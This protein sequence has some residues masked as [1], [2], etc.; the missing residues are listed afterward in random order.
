MNF[1]QIGTALFGAAFG[2]KAFDDKLP[3][4][5]R[6]AFGI[7]SYH[8]ITNAMTP[9]PVPVL[10]DAGAKVEADPKKLKF[11]EVRVRNI[12]ER[13]SRVHQQMIQG[14]RDPQVYALAREVLT[15]KKGDEWAVD[16]KDHLGEVKALYWEVRKRV[17][18]TWDPTD[19]DAFQTPRKTLALKAGDCDDFVSLLGA[20]LRS[21]GHKVRSRIVQTQGETTWNHIYLAVLV[22]GKWMALDPTVKNEPG[23]E[24]PQNLVIRKQDFDV[25]ET[26]AGPQLDK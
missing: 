10:G 22:N 21:V 25:V 7:I 11:K 6:G 2:V 16:E 15:R 26:G 13:V 12:Q 4:P 9:S 23:W 20:L 18:Y 1:A 17:R 8:Y 19:Y 14:T 24:V 3:W 5:V